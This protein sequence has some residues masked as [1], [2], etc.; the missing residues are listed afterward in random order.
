M[1]QRYSKVIYYKHVRIFTDRVSNGYTDCY[2]LEIT[3]KTEDTVLPMQEI[4]TASAVQLATNLPQLKQA[5][6]VVLALV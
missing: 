1:N 3:I 5:W 4:K 2:V 6:S